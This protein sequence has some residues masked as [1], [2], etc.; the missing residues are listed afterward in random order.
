[1]APVRDR[2]PISRRTGTVPAETID[3]TTRT[4]CKVV[5]GFAGDKVLRPLKAG[6][7]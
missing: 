1:M 6:R 3:V 5:P 2:K 4:V 7:G